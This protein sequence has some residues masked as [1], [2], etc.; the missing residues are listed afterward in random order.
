LNA[1]IVNNQDFVPAKKKLLNCRGHLLSME[2]PLLMGIL[3]V[4]SDSF[5]DGGRYATEKEW[6]KQTEKMLTEGADIIDIGCTSTRPGAKISDRGKESAQ[7]T[8]VIDSLLKHFPDIIISAD[9]YHASV[10][11]DAVSA[12]ASIIN[13]ISGGAMDDEMFETISRLNVPY[14]LMHI[15]G[16]PENMHLNPYYKDIWKEILIYFSEKTSKLVS[17]GLSDIIIDPGFG[18]GKNIDQNYALMKDLAMFNYFNYPLLVGI[19]RKSMIWKYLKT[20]PEEALNG[21]TVL[22]TIALLAGADILRV[23]DVKEARECIRI[24]EKVR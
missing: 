8:L 5:F 10:A 12:G 16:V 4:T 24:V 17:L 19:S 1:N 23:H 13:D 11:R 3:N 2:Q 9:T 15:Q 21:S 7:L 6:L 22:H 14:I 18:F 20:K